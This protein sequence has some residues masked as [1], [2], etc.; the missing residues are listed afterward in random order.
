MNRDDALRV[1]GS[2][3][4]DEIAKGELEE[5]HSV[6]EGKVYGKP[7]QQGI[8]IVA[9]EELFARQLEDAGLD[10]D[11]RSELWS[12]VD[13]HG[14]R[15]GVRQRQRST[16]SN[17]DL[18]IRARP[19]RFMEEVQEVDVAAGNHVAL[20]GLRGGVDPAITRHASILKLLL[21]PRRASPASLPRAAPWPGPCRSS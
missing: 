2:L 21:V 13:T 12:R 15:L 7:A 17:A 20:F 10:G 19:E 5:M 3:E 14:N 16:P 1:S 8:E 11:D 9:V 18:D 4:M 6:D